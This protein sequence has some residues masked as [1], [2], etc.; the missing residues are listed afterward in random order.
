MRRK[1]CDDRA[2]HLVLDRKDVFELAVVVLGPSMAPRSSV[3]QLRRDADAVAASAHAAFQH[4][5]YAQ[6]APDL[7][8]VNRLPLVLEA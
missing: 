5:A 2:H 7:A 4:I 6:L 1:E 8:H 3:D